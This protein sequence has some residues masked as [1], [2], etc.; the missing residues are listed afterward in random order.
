M[1]T[2]H[3]ASQLS[4]S[5]QVVASEAQITERDALLLTVQLQDLAIK[6]AIQLATHDQGLTAQDGTQQQ[7]VALQTASQAQLGA[8]AALQQPNVAL[9]TADSP[10]GYQELAASATMQQQALI[11][12]IQELAAG[13]GVPALLIQDLGAVAAIRQQ[14]ADA[15]IRQLVGGARIQQ[16]AAATL[17]ANIEARATAEAAEQR[18]AAA[19]QQ[20]T[21]ADLHER[22]LI[23][24][25]RAKCERAQANGLLASAQTERDTAHALVQKLQSDLNKALAVP[26]VDPQVRGPVIAVLVVQQGRTVPVQHVRVAP[27]RHRLFVGAQT[28]FAGQHKATG[29]LF[30]AAAQR[31]CKLAKGCLHGVQQHAPVKTQDPLQPPVAGAAA[32]RIPCVL[33]RGRH[34]RLSHRVLGQR[35]WPGGPQAQQHQR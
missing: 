35:A 20:Q 4:V 10:I 18:Q 13:A 28:P 17:I 26:S 30:L 27:A 2:Q 21:A 32:R 23:D 12:L 3:L 6:Q 25:A 24:L 9:F 8:S 31:C 33:V 1:D 16:E 15:H 7:T 19:E 34:L 22:L 29:M 11:Q 5:H 14:A